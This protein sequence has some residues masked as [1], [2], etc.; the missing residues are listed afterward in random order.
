MSPPRIFADFQNADPDG[1]VRLGCVGTIQDLAR[2]GIILRDGMPVVLYEE[3]LEADGVVQ[4]RADEHR[5]VAAIDWDQIRDLSDPLPEPTL[6][7]PAGEELTLAQVRGLVA[8]YSRDC[9]AV[10]DLYDRSNLG[11]H[12][13]LLPID[14]LAVNALNAFGPAQPMTPM[15]VAWQSR[16]AITSVVAAITRRELKTLTAAELAAAADTVSDA[17]VVIDGLHGFGSTASTKLLHRL[18]PNVTPIWDTKVGHLY[19]DRAYDDWR[20]WVRRVYA[21][22][23]AEPNRTCLEWVRAELPGFP[24]ILRVWDV[25]LW[26]Y[27]AAGTALDNRLEPA[28]VA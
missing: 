6:V 26:Q 8:D 3:T 28:A 12:D 27:V 19:P 25:V 18:R 13:D 2:L 20:V 9:P 21:D 5:W 15:T 10:F 24:P 22:V 1:R 11:P 14:L 16:D 17:L 7:L 23:L 4:F